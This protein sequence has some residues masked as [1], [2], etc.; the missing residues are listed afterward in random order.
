MYWLLYPHSKVTDIYID[1]H[2]IGDPFV[3]GPHDSALKYPSPIIHNFIVAST[4]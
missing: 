2:R 4:D 3:G 1:K